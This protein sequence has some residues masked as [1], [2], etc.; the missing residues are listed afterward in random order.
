MEYEST[1][2]DFCAIADCL[3]FD[4]STKD[5]QFSG[6]YSQGDGAS[7]TGNYTYKKGC[8]AA[9]EAYAPK[10]EALHAI[11]RDIVAMQKPAFYRI[12]GP[13]YRLSSRYSHENTIRADSD[14]LTAIARRLCQWLY[15]TL[16]SECEYQNA[17]HAGSCYAIEG[18]TIAES[19][20][21]LKAILAERRAVK[22]IAAPALCGAI[23]QTV[24]SLLA[25]IAKARARRAELIAGN[26]SEYGFW[27]GNEALIDAFKDGA[28]C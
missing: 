10:D 9:I 5:I 25:D 14:E 20:A 13:V 24:Q 22:G 12:E 23:R 8:V 28:Q 6:F 11:A 19:K 26:D 3:G 15:K 21:E 16:E 1:L 18:E 17:W 4:V 7:F 27:T 2:E